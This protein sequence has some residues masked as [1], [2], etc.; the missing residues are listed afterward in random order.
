[1]SF[2]V[3]ITSRMPET[4]SRRLSTFA[5]ILRSSARVKFSGSSLIAAPIARRKNVAT[6][7]SIFLKS[8]GPPRQGDRANERWA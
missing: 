4:S 7:Y 5:S 6:L 1:M 8:G 2:F 3:A